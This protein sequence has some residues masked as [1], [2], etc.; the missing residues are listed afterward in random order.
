VAASAPF[1]EKQPRTRAHAHIIND[2][3][4][5]GLRNVQISLFSTI[6]SNGRSEASIS[7]LESYY[8]NNGVERDRFAMSFK[9]WYR[10]PECNQQTMTNPDIEKYLGHFEWMGI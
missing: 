7:Q 2:W 10:L 8:V 1:R 9:P 4:W 3:E 5:L 6:Q